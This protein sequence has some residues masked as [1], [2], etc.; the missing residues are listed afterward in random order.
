MAYGESDAQ[1][2]DLRRFRVPAVSPF[3]PKSGVAQRPR[4]TIAGIQ[5]CKLNQNIMTNR[6]L[7]C[8]S[9]GVAGEPRSEVISICETLQAARAVLF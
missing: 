8:E 3:G 6:R 1:D 7:G 5:I 2:F 4:D 9:P